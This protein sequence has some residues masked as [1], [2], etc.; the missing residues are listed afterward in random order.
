MIAP[1]L[2]CMDF[3]DMKN[4][5]EYLNTVADFYHIDIM[6]LHFVPNITLSPD[7]IGAIKPA[8]K[9][10][11]DAHLMVQY[12]EKIIKSCADAGADYISLHVETINGKAFRLLQMIEDLDAQPGIAI[13]PETPLSE[14][15]AYANRVRKVTVMTVDPGFAGQPFIPEVLPKIAQLAEWKVKRGYD[16]IIEVDGGCNEAH[17]GMLKSAGGEMFIMGGSGLFNLDRDL[18]TAWE[19]MQNY[20]RRA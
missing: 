9:L 15:E 2:M 7:F 11:I 20:L 5:L 18:P 1:S 17:I 8:A 3:L 4:Q 6:D 12:P 14:M 19:K 13:N 10:P 16:Y